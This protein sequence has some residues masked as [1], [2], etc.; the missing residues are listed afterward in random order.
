[1]TIAARFKPD[2]TRLLSPK[3]RRSADMEALWQWIV[4]D[5]AKDPDSN[6]DLTA[7]EGRALYARLNRRWNI[8][9]PE[10]AKIETLQL[11]GL[12]GAPNISAQLLTPTDAKPGCILYVHGGGW[13]FG[14]LASH[15]RTMRMLAQET[16]T[17][18]LGID[19]RCP[20]EHPFPAPLEDVLAGWRW[21][22][23]QSR[24]NPDL[25]GPLAIAGDS[26]G[27]NLA[28][29]CI[30]RENELGRAAPQAGLLFYGVFSAD[31]DSPSYH[32]FSTGHG[33]TRERMAQFWDWYVPGSGPDSARLDPIVNQVA[34]TESVLAKLPPLYLNAAGMDVLLCDT[35]AFAERLHA[36]G[37][38]YELVV[39]EGVHH[40]FMQFS[41]K[42]EE[43]R[44]AFK[45]AGSFFRRTFS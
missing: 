19:Y 36:A 12:S 15:Q 17:R 18:V 43:T 42:L 9:L 27:A 45:M 21:L 20:P 4:A 30:M 7:Q 14:D 38:A 23:S 29:S 3:A 34:A 28:V 26:A 40:G 33:L 37:S 31:L 5:D 41:A 24:G 32:R 39:H 25:A 44:R 10:M 16:G 22:V 8:D 6:R 11:A 1:M 35:L 2:L 13:A